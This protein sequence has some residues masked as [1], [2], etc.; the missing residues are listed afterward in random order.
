MQKEVTKPEL[1]KLMKIFGMTAVKNGKK[2]KQM[3]KRV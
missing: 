2:R 3:G 1:Q